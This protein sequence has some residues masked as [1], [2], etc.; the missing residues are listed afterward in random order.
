[1][2]LMVTANHLFS[3]AYIKINPVFN[4]MAFVVSILIILHIIPFSWQK[5]GYM[6]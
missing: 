4:H 3:G 6:E 1:M 5:Q 2:D